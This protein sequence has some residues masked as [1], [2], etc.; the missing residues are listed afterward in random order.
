MKPCMRCNIEKTPI[1]FGTDKQ[2]S[3]GLRPYCKECERAYWENNKDARNKQRRES[4]VNRKEIIYKRNYA[5]QKKR[6]KEDPQFRLRGNLSR[7]INNALNGNIKSE[8]TKGLLGCS[9]NELRTYIE[10]KFQLGMSWDN[11]GKWHIDHIKPCIAFDLS[12]PRQQKE[13]FH[14][15]NLQPLWARDN[16][17][18][19]NKYE[20]NSL[21]GSKPSNR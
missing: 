7:R 9:I 2:K 12:I 8:R 20:S 17:A 5:Y 3:D 19:R 6:R 11:Y 4:Y 18:K 21:H 10:A 13:C 14:Y 1:E 16:I 15:T